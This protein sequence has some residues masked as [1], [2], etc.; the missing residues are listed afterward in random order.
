MVTFQ[1]SQGQTNTMQIFNFLDDS[2]NQTVMEHVWEDVGDFSGM[3]SNNL[4]LSK[5]RN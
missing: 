3:V 2:F 4:R 5:H 1:S